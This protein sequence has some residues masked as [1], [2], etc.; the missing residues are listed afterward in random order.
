MPA[1]YNGSFLKP[2]LLS[3]G[4]SEEALY[5]ADWSEVIYTV[6]DV[7]SVVAAFYGLDVVPELFGFCYAAYRGDVLRMGVYGAA[8]IVPMSNAFTP[9]KLA[10]YGKILKNGVWRAHPQALID[11]MANRFGLI[12]NR[13]AGMIQAADGLARRRAVKL[14]L[15]EDL[16]DELML[17]PSPDVRV[18]FLED[19]LDLS[20][21]GNNFA[22]H[23]LGKPRLVKAWGIARRAGLEPEIRLNVSDLDRISTYQAATSKS[24]DAIVA[25]I[26]SSAITAAGSTR[27]WLDNIPSGGG[28]QTGARGD[29]VVRESA[30]IF[31]RGLSESD[32]QHLLNTGQLR[33]TSETFTSPSLEYIQAIGYGG[34]GRIV[35]FYANHGTLDA[36]ESVGV[37]NDATDRIMGYFP[38]M[39]H[40]TTVSGWTQSRAMFKTEGRSLAPPVGPDGQ[41]N[42]GL[43]RGTAI[44][45]FNQ[46]LKAF[47]VVQ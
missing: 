13:V 35:K 34:D 21:R 20:P 12:N 30:E 14:M 29:Y 41:I 17:L 15:R 1:I 11:E 44:D 45:I 40:V 38:D 16:V 3:F 37:R 19:F 26:E 47:E 23:I 4:I 9:G 39:P 25:E 27:S 32:Y 7:A 2:E 5:P 33:P 42:I 31:Y 24:S 43:G 46:N 18:K 8:A 36:L 10:K 6:I 28:L 22:Q